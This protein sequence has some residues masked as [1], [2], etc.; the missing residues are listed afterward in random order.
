MCKTCNNQGG[1]AIEHK[2]GIQFEPCPDIHC[3]FVRDDSDIEQLWERLKES[4]RV[5]A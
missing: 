5:S 3:D 4:E 2:W 1:L